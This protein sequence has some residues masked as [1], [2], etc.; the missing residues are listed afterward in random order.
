M[1]K[2]KR[3]IE[4]QALR[5]KELELI[6]RKLLETS[7]ELSAGYQALRTDNQDLEQITSQLIEALDREGY[8]VIINGELINVKQDP[9]V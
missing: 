5:I 1:S 6:N 8:E 7:R 9:G 4:Q 2:A 3:T